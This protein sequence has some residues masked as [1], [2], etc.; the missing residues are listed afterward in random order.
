MQKT[1]RS[2]ALDDL[3]QG[4]FQWRIWLLLG[5]Q[6]I[7]VRYRRSYLGP[8][9]I[10][11]SMLITIYSMGLLYGRLFNMD[12]KSYLPHLAAGLLTWNLIAN[13]ITESTAAFTES[14]HYLKQIKLRYTTLIL[15]VLT[16]NFIIFIHNSLAFATVIIFL[17]IPVHWCDLLVLP[18][19]LLILLTGWSLGM[20]LAI[21]STR[22]R[23]FSPIATSL[24]QV[25]FFL[26][27]VIWSSRSLPPSYLFIVQW[28]PFARY[29]A[30]VR[31]PML[32]Q[33]PSIH[34]Y[35][36]TLSIT[37]GL[38]LFMFWLLKRVRHHII[39]WI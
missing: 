15:R 33:L 27:P 13:L 32:G 34:D 26:T 6:D 1:Q 16:R 5:W 38:F 7:K 2:K 24:V 9:W 17:H 35:V 23:D 10:T 14:Y 25:F 29:L 31:Q 37:A 39:F 11:L 20:I 4:F 18:G 3:M 30:L 21:T 12:M 36:I 8:F 19:L 22:F 28:N